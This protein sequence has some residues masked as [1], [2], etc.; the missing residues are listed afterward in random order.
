MSDLSRRLKCKSLR[1]AR[2]FLHLD[3]EPVIA[4]C[5][6]DSQ[7]VSGDVKRRALPPVRGFDLDHPFAAVGF[8]AGD[9]IAKAIAVLLR[10]PADLAG[11]IAASRLGQG[12]SFVVK[13]RLL[14]GLPKPA[15]ARIAFGNMMHPTDRSHERRIDQ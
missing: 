11:K 1:L 10:R 14:S 7:F 2:E 8:E 13:D 3:E 6:G 12:L 5:F 15:I 4:A 9:I